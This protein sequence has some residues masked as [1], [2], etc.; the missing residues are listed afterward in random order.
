MSILPWRTRRQILYFGLFSVIILT[1]IAG[2]VWY[3][4]PEPTCFDGRKNQ[5]EE[6]IDCGGPC[7]PCLKEI[8]DISVLWTRF[9]KNREGFYDVAALVENPNLFGGISSIGYK[10]GLYD[11]DNV[12]IA[13][14]KGS[15]FINPGERW[16]IFESGFSVGWRIPYRAYMEFDQQKNWKY[17]KKERPFLGVVRKDF[18]NFPFPRLSSEIKNDSLFDVKDVFV[19]A[20]LYDDIGGAVGVSFT[21]IDLIKA[22]S[23]QIAAFTWPQPFEKEPASIEV[24]ATTNLM[25]NNERQ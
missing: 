16:I 4:W 6:G 21:K 5:G 9:F 10:F 19:S 13:E 2:L 23:S 14:R 24:I 3:F 1:V 17:F 25:E 18:S 15:A 11:A 22:E 20:V 7:T 8:K 12:L